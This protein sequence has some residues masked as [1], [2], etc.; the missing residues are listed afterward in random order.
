MRGWVVNRSPY[1]F[2]KLLLD[3]SCHLFCTRLSINIVVVNMWLKYSLITLIESISPIYLHCKV[4][5]T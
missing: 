1:E 5:C 3:T 2:M 4:I